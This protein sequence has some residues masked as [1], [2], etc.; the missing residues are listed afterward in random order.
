MAGLTLT[1]A[2]DYALFL[3]LQLAARAPIERWA[4][5]HCGPTL[6]APESVPLLL[7]DLARL[8]V[9]ERLPKSTFAPPAGAHPLGLAWAIAGSHLG[10]RVQLA[11]L[12]RSGADLPTRFLADPRVVT[13]WRDLRPQL[14]A[15]AAET[16]ANGALLAAEAVFACFL[17]AL[18]GGAGRLAA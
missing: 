8:R 15:P 1:E 12:T 18:D 3:Q 2:G 14:E 7:D 6:R 4:Q 9:A 13:F 5:Q 17:R 16:P 11:V 10:N